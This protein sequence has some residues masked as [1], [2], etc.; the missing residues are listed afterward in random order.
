MSQ[1][2][3]MGA[4]QRDM[5]IAVL[6]GAAF[7]AIPF[8]GPSRYIIGQLTLFFLWVTV[9]SQWNLVFGVAGIFSL[10]HMALFAFGGYA[11]GMLGLYLKWSLWHAL[12]V[13][14]LGTVLFSLIIGLACL[15]L[16]GPYVALLTLAIAQAMY[17]L[18]ITDVAC[19]YMDGL[20]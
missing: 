12:P 19:F 16:R 2:S 1:N 10:G 5:T 17:L 11:T 8:L 14:A 15:R 6:I 9:V 3:G 4:I 7:T 13:A 20:T 18:I